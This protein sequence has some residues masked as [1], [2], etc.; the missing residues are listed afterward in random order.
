M[1]C[2]WKYRNSQRMNRATGPHQ[3]LDLVPKNFFL[4]W[5]TDRGVE[6]RRKEGIYATFYSSSVES[7][8]RMVYLP[9]RLGLETNHN[10]WKQCGRGNGAKGLWMLFGLYCKGTYRYIISG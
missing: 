8:E 5:E 6:V 10:S 7:G 1:R 2:F 4:V 9:L 3:L